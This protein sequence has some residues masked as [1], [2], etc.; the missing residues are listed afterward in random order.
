[1]ATGPSGQRRN[2]TQARLSSCS[3]SPLR[4]VC[5]RA[6]QETEDATRKT[7]NAR[8]LWERCEPLPDILAAIYLRSRGISD[9]THDSPGFYPEVIYREGNFVTTTPAIV[10]AIRVPDGT[11]RST[12]STVPGS[13]PASSTRWTFPSREK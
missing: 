8:R 1:M 12:P 13:I 5:N 10:A 3:D 6:V 9:T 4:Q 7:L 2:M 11:A